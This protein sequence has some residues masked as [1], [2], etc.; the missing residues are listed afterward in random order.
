MDI[1][2]VATAGSTLELDPDLEDQGTLACWSWITRTQTLD[3]DANLGHGRNPYLVGGV[4]GHMPWTR[5]QALDTD[6]DPYPVG[7][8]PGHRPWTGYP[9]ADF[10][11]GARTRQHYCHSE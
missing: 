8:V 5:T 1:T 6:A 9:D 4:P 7:R 10:G 11:R 3:A 2:L